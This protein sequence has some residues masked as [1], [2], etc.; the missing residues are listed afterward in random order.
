MKIFGCTVYVLFKG[1][2]SKLDEKS[3]KGIFVGYSYNGYKVLDVDKN[4]I[5]VARDVV[6]DET[7]FKNTRPSINESITKEI[8]TN[9]MKQNV[10]NSNLKLIN[11]SITKEIDTD[12][13]KSTRIKNMP[14]VSYKEMIDGQ[15]CYLTFNKPS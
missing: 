3:S 6:F 11:K 12:Q 9:D 10:I 2:R 7:N 5:I 8:E 4:K 15:N 13:R 14:R 1:A